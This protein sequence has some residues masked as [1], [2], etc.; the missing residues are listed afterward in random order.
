MSRINSNVSSIIAQRVLS[1]QNSRMN[2]SLQRLSTGLRINTGKDDPA[3]LIASE[4]MRAEKVAIQAAQTNVMRAT[5]V[6]AV[7]E[8]GLTEIS[9]L[10]NDMEELIDRSANQ[11]GIS[12]DER[13]ANQLEI[14]TILTS[15]D[16]IANSTELQGR[17][18]L[19]GELAYTTSNIDTSKIGTLQLYSSR[20]PEGGARNV[21]VGV[22]TAASTAGITYSGG[23]VTGSARSIEV[24]GN[25][26][27][28]VLTFASGT[29]A[30]GIAAA[31]ND[32][33][34]LTGVSASVGASGA[35]LFSSTEYGSSQFVKVRSLTGASF[36]VS[37]AEDYGVDAEV[38]ING[39]AA[40]GDGLKVSVRSNTLDADITLAAAFGSVAGGTSTF[41]IT[42]GGANFAIAPKLDLNSIATLGIDAVTTTS[43]GN[44]NTGTLNTIGT[45]GANALTQANFFAAQRIIRLAAQQVAT[46]RGRLGAFEKDTLDTTANSL[47]IQYENLTAAES[48]IR[49]ADFAEET[50]NLTRAQILVQSATNVLKLANQAPQN[51]LSLLQ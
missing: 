4:T 37:A 28:E 3:G 22:N 36:T 35:V 48:A 20:I 40:I 33:R 47:S 49:D 21:V 34:Y 18:L 25:L 29:T 9:S 32:S 31:V 27:R 2:L 6:V 24:I 12:N 50:S 17:R 8:S 5:N 7:A 23:T 14:D 39:T 30:S 11:T 38:S 43:L 1:T 46:M 16:R 10:L 19:S 26:G 41:S 15:I 42:G 45:G 51:V 44:S 13:A